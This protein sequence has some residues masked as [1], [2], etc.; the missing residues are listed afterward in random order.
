MAYRTMAYRIALLF[1]C[2]AMTLGC[3]AQGDV[4]FPDDK[5]DKAPAETPMT[6]DFKA[7]AV[8]ENP[9]KE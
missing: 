7:P 2:F 1:V 9:G 4:E 8:D 6:P 5:M 3:G